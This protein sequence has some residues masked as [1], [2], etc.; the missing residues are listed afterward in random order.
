MP[1]EL[2]AFFQLIEDYFEASGLTNLNNEDEH[3]QRVTILR[4]TMGDACR[5]AMAGVP[6]DQKTTYAL[7]KTAIRKR[8]LTET[9]P[10]HVLSLICQ[11]TMGADEQVKDFVTR[12]WAL[13]MRLEDLPDLWRE[14][15][16]LMALRRGHAKQEVCDLLIKEQPKTVPDAERICEEF[17]ARQQANASCQHQDCHGHGLVSAHCSRG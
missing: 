17:D 2:D 14:G 3:L 13:V 15:L 9:D 16:V 1:Q 7:F 8:Y 4:S 6:A 12:L 11:C 10:V 5:R